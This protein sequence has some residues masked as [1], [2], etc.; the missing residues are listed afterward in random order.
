MSSARSPC[1][2]QGC[3]VS[4]DRGI[5][6]RR[7][8]QPLLPTQSSAVWPYPSPLK[9]WGFLPLPS[10]L[11]DPKKGAAEGYAEVVLRTSKLQWGEA[12]SFWRGWLCRVALG[13][14]PLR[15]DAELWDGSWRGLW[16]VPEVA[17]HPICE[18]RSFQM[19]PPAIWATST[20]TPRDRGVT[21]SWCLVPLAHSQMPRASQKCCHFTWSLGGLSHSS[22]GSK[23]TLI[24]NR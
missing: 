4:C 24:V 21:F 22:G 10:N 1:W 8:Q 15:T 19:L 18:Q 11:S 16:P 20:F 23:H 17:Q 5:F 13:A 9:G 6:Q 14:L 7:P 12:E 3:S 2:H